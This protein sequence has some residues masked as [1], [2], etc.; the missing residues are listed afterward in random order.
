MK[1]KTKALK[2][3]DRMIKW[4]EKQK[5]RERLSFNFKGYHRMQKELGEH[6]G[7]V[8]C[9]YCTNLKETG[10]RLCPLTKNN[11]FGFNCCEGLWGKMRGSK[12]WGTWVKRAKLVREYIRE[13]G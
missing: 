11:C 1:T 8:Y 10:N 5:P 4:A 12:T 9:P 3:Y 13:N 6:W 7:G 2:H